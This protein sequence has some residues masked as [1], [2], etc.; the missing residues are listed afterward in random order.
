VFSLACQAGNVRNGQFDESGY[1]GP[2]DGIA[3]L[4]MEGWA[5]PDADKWPKGWSGHGSGVTLERYPHGGRIGDPF[6]RIRGA[7]GYI[8]SNEGIE[9]TNLVSILTVWVKGGG[10]IQVGYQGYMSSDDGKTPQQLTSSGELPQPFVVKVESSTWVRYQSVVEKTPKLRQVRLTVTALDGEIDF[11][12]LDLQPATPARELI[13]REAEKLYG[14]HVLA[15]DKEMVDANGDFRRR[16]DEYHAACDA[17]RAKSKS[18]DPKLVESLE[19]EIKGLKQY[20]EGERKQALVFKFN[21]ML[22]LTRV[23]ATLAK[24]PDKSASKSE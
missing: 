19:A 9:V 18:L 23:C 3:K 15:E 5:C 2:P 10:V 16:L 6:C 7:R 1:D 20:I 12:E 11:D 14:M 17:M 8:A 24:R 21:D 4:R 22:L 13:A